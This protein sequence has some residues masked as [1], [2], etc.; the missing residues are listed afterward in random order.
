MLKLP[1]SRWYL[2][3]FLAPMGQRETL[4]PTS[5]DERAR[6]AKESVR[7]TV[8]FAEYVPE[9]REVEGR[10]KPVIVW[11]RVPREARSVE[12]ALDRAAIETGA[13]VP[14]APGIW[15]K[16]KL[17]E[18][19][20]P[21]LAPRTRALSLFVVNQR[22]VE[23]EK[24]PFDAHFIF[25]V[26]LAVQ[27]AG[28]LVARPNRRGETDGEWDDRLPWI[29]ILFVVASRAALSHA[30]DLAFAVALILW[31]MQRPRTTA[32]DSLSAP[33]PSALLGRNSY[34]RERS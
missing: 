1:P 4:D 6:Y 13:M 27:Y 17:E 28:G 26:E 12:L 20:A 3:G 10:T 21:G 32:A 11:R 5:D 8:R 7:A 34:E 16:G 30:A 14:D 18:A 31:R 29:S 33:Q 19:E 9:P 22:S 24:A 2:T 15:V 25:Q 23:G